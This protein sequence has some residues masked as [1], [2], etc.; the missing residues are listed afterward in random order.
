LL[1]QA[2]LSLSLGSSSLEA[3]LMKLSW[4]RADSGGPLDV[5]NPQ[6]LS[7]LSVDPVDRKLAL[8]M[9]RLSLLLGQA[10]ELQA[11]FI[12]GRKGNAYALGGRWEPKAF[13]DAVPANLTLATLEAGLAEEWGLDKSQAGLRF[14]TSLSGLDLGAQYFYGWLRDP[15]LYL[16]GSGS[17]SVAYARYHQLGFDA[18][19]VLAG[20]ALRGE[21]ALNLGTGPLGIDISGADPALPN[22]ALAFDLSAER[23]LPADVSLALRWSGSYRFGT[24]SIADSD[25]IEFGKPALESALGLSLS[26]T[27]LKGA[28]TA[29]IA[30]VWGISDAD[31]LINPSLSL[32]FGDGI[33]GVSAGIYGG[34]A[35]GSLGQYA[36]ASY[37]RAGISFAF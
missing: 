25:D 16:P 10:S 27:F 30:G 7:D 29:S 19:L 6:D 34:S 26:R 13:R 33:L 3:G 9:A 32:N 23:S 20:I 21:A 5:L 37:I 2:Y 14:T 4:G 17:P 31:Y 12:P 18:A 28:L 24:S 35:S 1:D 8:P 36:S 15:V 22:P 11:A